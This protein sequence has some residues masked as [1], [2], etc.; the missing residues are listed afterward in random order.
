[1]TAVGT[2]P[3]KGVANSPCPD[4][5]RFKASW[6]Y[7]WTLSPGSCTTPE[8]VPMVSGK[9]EKTTAAVAGALTRVASAGFKTV[10]GFNEPNKV[11]QANLTVAQVVDLWPALTTNPA[12]RVGSPATSGDAQAWFND[13]MAQVSARNLRVDFIAI[14][15]Y[16][17]NAGSCDARAL[18]LENYI[19]WAEAIPGNRPIWIT[20]WGCLNQSNPDAA[21]VQA[22]YTG[23]IAMFARHP[24]IERYA[25][26][27][28]IPNNELVAPGGALTPLGAALANAPSLR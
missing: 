21:T 20:E 19:K 4:L 7:N 14:H 18:N 12:I 9:N 28:W 3:F 2:Q 26:Y 8:F 15:W 17:W 22:F 23:A 5:A 24:R 6:F 10:L 27:P 16:G 1:M 25:W 11:D 13:F